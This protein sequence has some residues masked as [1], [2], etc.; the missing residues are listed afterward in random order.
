[1]GM[2]GQIGG[3][4]TRAIC[5]KVFLH[6]LPQS[7]SLLEWQHILREHRRRYASL[8]Q[9]LLVNPAMSVKDLDP[10]IHNPLAPNAENPWN[11]YFQDTELKNE[12]RKD[13]DRTYQE[14]DFFQ[15][16]LIKE[17]MLQIL[18]LWCKQHPDISYRQGMN[19]LLAPII[20]TLHREKAS[21]SDKGIG[22]E[23]LLYTLS[24]P[25]QVEADSYT[26]FSTIMDYGMAELFRPEPNRRPPPRPT[27]EHPLSLSPLSLKAQM[28]KEKPAPPP[29]S[30][31][32]QRC[33]D[34]Y[35]KY[36]PFADKQLYDHLQKQGV[37][38]QLFL[39]RWV[40]LLLGREFHL[41]DVMILWDAMFAD[42][43]GEKQFS[44]VNYICVAM[45]IYVRTHLLSRD[46]TGCL[47]RL[48]K[49]PPT[50]DV[51]LLVNMAD[52]LRTTLHEKVEKQEKEEKSK[53]SK[54]SLFG[55]KTSK[56]SKPAAPI[57]TVA[58]VQRQLEGV[59]GRNLRLGQKLST[60]INVLQSELTDKNSYDEDNVFKAL[61][62]LKQIKDVLIQRLE[63]HPSL[64]QDDR[65]PGT[66]VSTTLSTSSSPASSRFNSPPRDV[67]EM[68]PST[69]TK[70]SDLSPS[71]TTTTAASP[72]RPV[73]STYL[74]AD[75]LSGR[76]IAHKY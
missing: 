74:F 47:Q 8:V 3:T 20:Y 51:S 12:I 71:S 16:M 15:N 17:Q 53:L 13:I 27:D 61:A 65:S 25:T 29:M 23:D 1:M 4:F 9:T 22:P 48:L 21:P 45:L 59:N 26:L 5:W 75:P 39:L 64:Y 10:S 40:R 24:D 32:L 56:P 11:S 68:S 60:V 67:V 70:T 30:A 52:K 18:F 34:I 31:V 49:Y 2:A 58:D 54:F 6:I 66:E 7:C 37:E 46:N 69:F 44:F 42:Y 62:E 19:E 35:H 50:E 76:S 28:Q 57:I 63:D 73:S 43:N 72:S 55:H 14:K 41:E 36:L 38:P 33:H